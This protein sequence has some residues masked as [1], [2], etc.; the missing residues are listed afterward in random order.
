M[1]NKRGVAVVGQGF[2]L[3]NIL[4]EATLEGCSIKIELKIV[5][6]KI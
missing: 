4:K 2:S 6:D 5:G 1:R 3:A